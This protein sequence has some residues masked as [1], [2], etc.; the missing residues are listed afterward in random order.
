MNMKK[1]FTPA[2]LAFFLATSAI[3]CARAPA[4]NEWMSVLGTK[5]SFAIG[6]DGKPI[7]IAQKDSAPLMLFNKNTVVGLFPDSMMFK[8]D[9]FFTGL[10]RSEFTRIAKEVT[11]T[12]EGTMFG[13]ALV[14]G[15]GTVLAEVS[16]F[17]GRSICSAFRRKKS[18]VNANNKHTL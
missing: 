15:L 4:Q 6:A 2:V 7:V 18:P 16:G 14:L 3:S 5:T 11:S 9:Q 8:E 1:G 12:P 13:L 10:K 17:I